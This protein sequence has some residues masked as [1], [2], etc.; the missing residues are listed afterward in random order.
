MRSI[1]KNATTIVW[2]PV[3]VLLL[4]SILAAIFGTYHFG[5]LVFRLFSEELYRNPKVVTT[6][7]LTI[8]D[9]YLL[10]IFQLIFSVGLYELFIGPLDMP[11][12]L[13][14]TTI[15]Q[16]KSTLASVII[17]VLAIFFTNMSVETNNKIDIL[18]EGVGIAAIIGALIFY[19]KVKTSQ[20]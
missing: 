17:L 14:I 7:L 12:W 6:D 3:I 19:Y 5:V 16:L 9:M 10:V 1:F 4:G 13:T 15:D 2:I 8:I 11:K 20:E 18:Y